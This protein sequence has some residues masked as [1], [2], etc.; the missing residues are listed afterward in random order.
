[1]T[2]RLPTPAPDRSPETDGFWNATAENRLLLPSC[3]ECGVIIWYPRGFCPACGSVAISQSAATGRGSIYS[4][5]V[6]HR[7]AGDYRD[8]VPYVVAYVELEEGPRVLT[9]IV[10]CQPETVYI[11]QPVRLVFESTGEGSALYRFEPAAEL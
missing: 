10:G 7:T 4:F 5:T 1:V 6:V 11:G 2:S 8:A 3:D 9:N